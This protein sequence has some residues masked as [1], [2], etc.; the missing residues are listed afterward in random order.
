MIVRRIIR[1]ALRQM[2]EQVMEV[3]AGNESDRKTWQESWPFDE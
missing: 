1:D 2:K 3:F